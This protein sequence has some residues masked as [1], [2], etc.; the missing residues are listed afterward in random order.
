[1][2]NALRNHIIKQ[3]IMYILLVVLSAGEFVLVLAVLYQ[4]VGVQLVL[5]AAQAVVEGI[6]EVQQGDVVVED[7]YQTATQIKQ[8]ALVLNM[9]TLKLIQFNNTHLEE[10]RRYYGR[11]V[12]ALVLREVEWV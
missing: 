12:L 3:Q 10:D 5:I 2:V 9:S 1:M 6:L 8:P 7:L 4:I 11:M